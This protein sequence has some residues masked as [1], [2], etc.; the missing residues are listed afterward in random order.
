MAYT[1][2][3]KTKSTEKEETV[4]QVSEPTAVQ[5]EEMV[6]VSK[7]EFDQMKA[8]MQTLMQMIAMGNM[9]APEKKAERYITFINM[10]KGRY[11]L[12]G[13][14]FYTIDNQFQSRSFIERE[15]KLIVNNMPNSIRE[16][17]VYIADADFVKECE[18]DM[19]YEHL[20]TDKD[21]IDLLNHE[22][23]YVAEVYK[24]ACDG[25]KKIIV[26]M[27]ESKKFN[28]D[29]VDA[30]ILLQIGQLSGKDLINMETLEDMKEG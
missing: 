7:S 20:L 12:K 22:P 10:T 24:N 14:S 5:N 28:G 16:G 27:I 18:L 9:A 3:A 1:S 15:A 13:S 26:D 19:V 23:S 4:Q 30:N 25:Q 11:V 29:Y 21:M 6:T 8:Q 17:K 2:K